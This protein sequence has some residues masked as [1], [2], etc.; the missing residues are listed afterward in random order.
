MTSQLIL[1]NGFGVAIAS[2]SAASY[3]ERTYEDARKIRRLRGQHRLAVMCSGGVNLLGMPVVAL[4]GQWEQTLATKLRSVEDYRD[5]FVI[6][7]ERNLDSWSSSSE[8]DSEALSSLKSEIM[9]LRDRVQRRIAVLP[10]EERLDEAMRTLQEV[11]ASVGPWDSTLAGMADQLLDRFSNEDLGE[12]RLPRLQTVVD[13]FFEEI[14]RGEKIEHEFHEYLRRLPGRSGWFP[15]RAGI[16][17]TFVG[18][19]ADE[20]LPVVSAVELVGAIENHLSA[21]DRRTKMAEPFDGGFALAVPIAQTDVMDLIIKGFDQDLIEA[22]MT[23][24]GRSNLPGGHDIE[25]AEEY[26]E[27]TAADVAAGEPYTEF[28]SA[29]IDTTREMAWHSKER[30]FFR[31]IAKL[32]LASLAEAAG[33]LVSVQNLSQNIHGELPS[34]G[35]PIDVATITLSEGF[36]WV[37]GGGWEQDA[38]D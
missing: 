29:V 23:R 31:T 34:V 12:G 26:A 35:G 7:L 15:G 4:V 18:Y 30:P 11:H 27:V 8:R 24:V 25:S 28:A 10:E 17:L 16:H 1:G 9:W 13:L 37:R 22:A 14:P 33:S 20:L 5:S 38:P 6:W 36:Q 2:D 32:E 21:F 19:G 3:F